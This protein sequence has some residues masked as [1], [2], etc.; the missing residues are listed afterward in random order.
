MF[1]ECFTLEIKKSSIVIALLKLYKKEL[2][3]FQYKTP[4]AVIK[5]S[6]KG[7]KH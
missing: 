5:A 4:L 3:Y 2:V 1:V 6:L 7:N